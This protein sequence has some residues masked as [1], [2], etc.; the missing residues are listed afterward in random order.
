LDKPLDLAIPQLNGQAAQPLPATFAVST[1]ALSAGESAHGGGQ[2]S[3][4]R[5]IGIMSH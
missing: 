5:G 3:G 2:G 4:D 1:H